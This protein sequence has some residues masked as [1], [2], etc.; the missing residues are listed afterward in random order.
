MEEISFVCGQSISFPDT[1]KYAFVKKRKLNSTEENFV[2]IPL[3][4]LSN[5]LKETD[6]P[7]CG[8]C[9]Q[10]L[11]NDQVTKYRELKKDH[12]T[13]IPNCGSQQCLV[14]ALVQTSRSDG[15]YTKGPG[16]IARAAKRKATKEAKERAKRQSLNP[17]DNST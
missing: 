4:H 15:F 16:K 10:N 6:I 8:W 3:K 5:L 7:P 12:D 17:R 2:R 13:V 11:S 9:P 1:P 14:K